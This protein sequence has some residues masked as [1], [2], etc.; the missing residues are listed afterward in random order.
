MK[1]SPDQLDHFATNTGIGLAGRFAGRFL[2][3]L[4]SL[5]AARVL[6]PAGFGLYALGLT[7]FRLIELIAPLGFDTG[8]IKYGASHLTQEND[9]AVKGM[10]VWSLMVSLFFSSLLAGVIFWLSPWIA[11]TI[12]GQQELTVV[13]R[14]FALILP[15][16][17]VLAILSA[18]SRLKQQIAFSVVVHDF[19]QPLLAVVILLLFWISELNIERIISAD[20]LSYFFSVLCAVYF[21]KLLFPFI[22]TKPINPAI[23]DKGYFSFSLAS[24]ASIFLSTLVLWV[25]RLFVA[26]YLSAEDMGMYQAALQISVIFAIL[27]SSFSR[28]LLPTFSSLYAE[29]HH[30]EMQEVFRIGTKWSFYFGL[31]IIVFI[32]LNPEDILKIMYGNTYVFA[33]GALSILLIGQLINLATGA[34]GPLLLVGGY[35]KIVLLLSGASLIFNVLLCLTLIPKLGITGAALSNTISIILMY[36]IALLVVRTKMA[37]WPYDIR[38]L[39]GILSMGIASVCAFFIKIPFENLPMLQ[40]PIQFVTMVFVF[41]FS[42]YTLGLYR[43]DR[44]FILMMLGRL[45]IKKKVFQE[46]TDGI[47]NKT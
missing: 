16:S 3:V 6:G 42:L 32:L 1:I 35:H 7:I 37:L 39:K 8:L 26:I 18:A 9:R 47:S 46:D 15:L 45:G 12:F 11:L 21:L 19:G 36:L 22:F 34:V 41:I 2:S 29:N 13:F 31:P 43:E 23:S 28:V 38:Y 27:M 33:G 20:L 30:A 14:L 5:I 4:E 40:L 10:I 24:A 25:D 17:A 44:I